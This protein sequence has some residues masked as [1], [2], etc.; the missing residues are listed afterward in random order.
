V[1]PRAAIPE[2]FRARSPL[3]AASA[4]GSTIQP[5]LR[6]FVCATRDGKARRGGHSLAWTHDDMLPR[7]QAFRRRFGAMHR[8]SGRGSTQGDQQAQCQD[9]THCIC[10]AP[11]GEPSG[12]ARRAGP[13]GFSGLQGW[14]RIARYQPYADGRSSSQGVMATRSV[15]SAGRC[16]RTPLAS[17]LGN[18]DAGCCPVGFLGSNAAGPRRLRDQGQAI[19]SQFGRPG[20]R[21]WCI[22]R[23]TFKRPR[24]QRLYDSCGRI[25]CAGGCLAARRSGTVTVVSM[26]HSFAINVRH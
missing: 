6:L 3:S 17:V 14:R 18:P 9:R 15:K 4:G 22:R 5:I 11:I 25:A 7:T 24:W 1:I 16:D 21:E 12:P 10:S 19:L 26:T 20:R 23:K 2:G 8:C 13:N